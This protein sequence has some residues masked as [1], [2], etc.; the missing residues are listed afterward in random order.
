M[1]TCVYT[2]VWKINILF[3]YNENKNAITF[4]ISMQKS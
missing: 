2:Y 1:D 3:S 4:Y